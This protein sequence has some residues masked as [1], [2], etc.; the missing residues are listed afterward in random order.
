MLELEV[1]GKEF[2]KVILT[3]KDLLVLLRKMGYN[4]NFISVSKCEKCQEN[5]DIIEKLKDKISDLEIKIDIFE[6]KDCDVIIDALEA[7]LEKAYSECA[8]LKLK[9]EANYGK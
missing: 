7:E 5:T 4:V 9:L 6:E 2:N 8:E 1:Y 3:E